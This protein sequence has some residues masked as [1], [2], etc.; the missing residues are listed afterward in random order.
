[1]ETRFD[2]RLA[3]TDRD[4]R[5]IAR[6]RRQGSVHYP[7]VPAMASASA[8]P[9]APDPHDYNAHVFGAFDGH[10]AVGAMRLHVLRE[11][12]CPDAQELHLDKFGHYYPQQMGT[13]SGFTVA[14]HIEKDAEIVAHL[15]RQA[16][17]FAYLH[18][19]EFVCG[20]FGATWLPMMETLGWRRYVPVSACP[21]LDGAAPMC[22]VLSDS[23]HLRRVGSPYTPL[24]ATFGRGRFAVA[25][26]G[27]MLDRSERDGSEPTSGR[28]IGERRD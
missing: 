16:L 2:F 23:D 19:L 12:P 10:K 25:Y 17:C 14:R 3:L 8:A 4:R 21:E 22:F 6:L 5:E 24:A 1:M 9:E 11:S 7:E 27:Q 13:V 20:A 18:Q 15:M 26:F 28:S